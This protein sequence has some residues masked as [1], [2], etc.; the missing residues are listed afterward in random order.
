MV[1]AFVFSG[2]G[3]CLCLFIHICIC[4]Y[5][6]AYRYVHM[7]THVYVFV[8]STLVDALL[9]IGIAACVCVYIGI[10][11][12]VLLHTRSSYGPGLP[13]VILE[14]HYKHFGSI[15]SIACIRLISRIGQNRQKI[16][17]RQKRSEV[18]ILGSS[19]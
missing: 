1:I 13:R 10:Y 3:V 16:H 9:L 12:Y 8:N 17:L 15:F 11:I 19:I 18:V 4:L 6:Y 5:I 7:Y 14:L 2:I